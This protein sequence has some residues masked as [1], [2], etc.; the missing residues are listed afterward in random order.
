MQPYVINIYPQFK[1]KNV[2]VSTVPQELWEKKDLLEL[3]ESL[4]GPAVR[5]GQEPMVKMLNWI[6][7]Q[8][9]HVL[10]VLVVLPDLVDLR[11]NV[12]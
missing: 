11:E 12:V 9:Y 10:S 7:N 2:L 6:L 4:E 8:I 5:V 3:M 1:F